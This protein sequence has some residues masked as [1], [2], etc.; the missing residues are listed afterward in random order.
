MGRRIDE[1][2][3][4]R[5]AVE[6]GAPAVVV[7]RIGTYTG[8]YADLDTGRPGPFTVLR[9]DIDCVDAN[10]SADGSH[11][12]AR[13]GFV[14]VNPGC[15]HACGHDGHT[16][17]GL[18]L[19]EVD[20]RTGRLEWKNPLPL[21]ARGGGGARRVCHDAR[22]CRGWCGLFSRDAPGSREPDRRGLRRGRRFSLHDE[23]RRRF[24]G[25]RGARRRR[26]GEGQK[27]AARSQA[28]PCG[29]GL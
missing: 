28:E 22:R 11:L 26:A 21:P 27:R 5:R 10:E 9:F 12:P 17:V 29:A 15:M 18:A 16:A 4:K 8:L 13:E 20:R 2:A 14:S 6:Q 24:H 3:E 19:A 25:V 7:D 1:A 23:D